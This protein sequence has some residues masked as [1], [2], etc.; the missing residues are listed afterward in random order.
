MV[1]TMLVAVN[2]VRAQQRSASPRPEEHPSAEEYAALIAET[3]SAL[4]L[5]VRSAPELPVS[6]ATGLSA[7]LHAQA[8]MLL[9]DLSRLN[10]ED[11]AS[12]LA[13]ARSHFGQLPEGMLDQMP[14][15]RDLSVL[16]QLIE[17]VLPPDDEAVQSMIDRNPGRWDR[18]G[19]DMQRAML[20]VERARRSQAPEDIGSALRDLQAVWI[21]LDAGSPM[22]AQLLIAMATMQNLLAAQAGD[23]LSATDAASTATEAVGVA[24]TPSEVQAAAQLLVITFSLMLARGQREGPFQEADDALRTAL[25]SAGPDD[26][27][28]RLTLLT[29]LGASGTLGAAVTGDEARRVAAGQA[30]A[31]AERLLPAPAP[32]VQWYSAA[33]ILCTWAAAQ[34][35]YGNDP[36]A[37]GLALRL[38]GMLETVLTDHPAVAQQAAGAPPGQEDP[39][40]GGELD[41]LQEVR[42]QLLAME[43]PPGAGS[44]AR[45]GHTGRSGRGAHRRRSA[46]DRQPQR[47]SGGD[48]A[49][50]RRAWCPVAA[51]ARRGRPAG[52][53]SAA[54][55]R[56]G[57]APGLARRGQR[58]PAAAAG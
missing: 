40:G 38:I 25:A 51:A 44:P 6:T 31:D 52:P 16:E 27:V 22:R 42:Q 55:A 39:A 8:A 4:D 34:G 35:L 26:W 29:A 14:V 47:G 46:R 32:T 2:A 30:I 36:D 18:S 11:R 5:L 41:G 1:T 58:L 57:P 17:G 53:R 20:A 33:R 50:P 28:L 54:F 10:T 37:A 9:V 43:N 12:L 13:R 56:R 49:R 7:S 24:T 23:Q 15:L 45:P 21:G 19:G 3:E 48:S